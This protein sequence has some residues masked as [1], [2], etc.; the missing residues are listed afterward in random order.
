MDFLSLWVEKLN[1]ISL[2]VFTTHNFDF[3]DKKFSKFNLRV[4]ARERKTSSDERDA[5][6]IRREDFDDKAGNTI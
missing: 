5:R 2:N 3:E 4:K 6:E 1:P